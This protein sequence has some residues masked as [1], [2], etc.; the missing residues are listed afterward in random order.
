MVA[1]NKSLWNVGLIVE[2]VGVKNA[3]PPCRSDAP[4]WGKNQESMTAYRTRIAFVAEKEIEIAPPVESLVS[5]ET[6][7]HALNVDHVS[8]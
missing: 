2:Q 3:L 8:E 7:V 1:C 5:E 4:G 6:V